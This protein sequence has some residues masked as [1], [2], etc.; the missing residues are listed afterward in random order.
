MNN[1]TSIGMFSVEMLKIIFLVCVS[2]MMILTCTVYI[3]I[4]AIAFGIVSNMSFNAVEHVMM[5]VINVKFD[6]HI[7]FP[8]SLMQLG[9]ELQLL[10]VRFANIL[11]PFIICCIHEYSTLSC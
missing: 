9:N 8:K 7:Q 1:L 4:M 2:M 6:R 3:Y 5:L 10:I 11:S